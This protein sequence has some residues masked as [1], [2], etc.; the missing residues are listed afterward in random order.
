[1]KNLCKLKVFKKSRTTPHPSHFNSHVEVVNKHITRYLGDFVNSD[2]LDWEAFIPA[3]AFA[4]NTIIHR[5]TINTP[6]H[7]ME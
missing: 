4:H 2:T 6:F 5:T 3:M 1:M 7:H